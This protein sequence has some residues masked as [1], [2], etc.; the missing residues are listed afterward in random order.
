MFWDGSKFV[1]DRNESKIFIKYID[2]WFH[3]DFSKEEDEALLDLGILRI[4][5]L[6]T[7]DVPGLNLDKSLEN[8]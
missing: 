7:E 2:A 3:W 6:R 1:L 8:E 5:V 4:M